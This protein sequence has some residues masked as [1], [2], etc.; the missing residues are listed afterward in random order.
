M[1][2]FIAE[3]IPIR[4]TALGTRS[5]RRL[6]AGGEDTHCPQC[7]QIVIRRYGF[8]VQETALREG[9]CTHCGAAIAG[10]GL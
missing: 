1:M 9:R 4:T 5:P 3:C 6:A 10:V 8:Y 7:G 2:G